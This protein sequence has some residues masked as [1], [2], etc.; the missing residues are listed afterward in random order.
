MIAL[1]LL[2]NIICKFYILNIVH[3]REVLQ[4]LKR[5][6]KSSVKDGKKNLIVFNSVIPG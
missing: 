6:I 5:K 3:V 4:K 2:K 1:T